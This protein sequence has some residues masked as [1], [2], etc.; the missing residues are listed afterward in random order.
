M[1]SVLVG[2]SGATLSVFPL[3]PVFFIS[4]GVLVFF[5]GYLVFYE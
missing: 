2:T 5:Y 3:D 1:C 4:S